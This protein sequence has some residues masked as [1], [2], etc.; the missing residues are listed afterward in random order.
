LSFTTWAYGLFIIFSS[1]IYWCLPTIIRKYFLLAAS[2]VFLIYSSPSTF[3][4]LLG[5]SSLGYV[6]SIKITNRRLLLA[7]SITVYLMVLLYFKY[8]NQLGDILTNIT[9]WLNIE[10]KITLPRPALA[11]GISFFTFKLIHY[12]V[13]RFKGTTVQGTYIQ[14]LLYVFFFPIL[15]SGP[16]ERWPN[17]IRQTIESK[18][19]QWKYLSEG[20]ER[21]IIGLFKKLVLADILAIYADK[22]SITGLSSN[23]YWVIVYAYAFRLYFDFSGYSDIAIGCSRIFGYKIMENFNNPYFK[24]NISEFWKNWHMS[25]TSWFTDYVFIPLGGSRSSFANTIMNTFIVMSLT[26]L[27]HG[28]SL[29]FLV[30]GLYHGA[31]LILLR[32][33]NRFICPKLPV[34]YQS[35]RVSYLVSTLITFHFVVIGWVFFTTEIKHSFYVLKKLFVWG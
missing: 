14:F 10:S 30:W 23:V 12:L 5:M 4:L 24:R 25:L 35:S 11:L 21:I 31:G 27:W 8:L 17:F 1:I 9:P 18:G 3:F 33:Y 26:G 22:I 28:G 20:L 7:F 2:M 34:V 32:F 15:P 13:E 6:V 29:N 16:I 19:F